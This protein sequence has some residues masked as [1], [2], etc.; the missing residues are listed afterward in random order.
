[1]KTKAIGSIFL[2]F[3]FVAGMIAMSPTG[4]AD[5]LHYCIEFG[6]VHRTSSIWNR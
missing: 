2:L 1:M 5:Y 6:N 4:Y 3:T